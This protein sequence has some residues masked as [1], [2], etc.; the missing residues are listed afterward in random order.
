M[1]FYDRYRKGETHSVYA[2]I[3]KLGEEAFSPVFYTDVEKV[4]METFRRVKLNLDIIYKE[5]RNI[6]YVFWKDEEGNIQALLRPLSDVDEQLDILERNIESIGKLPMSVKMFYKTVG[7]CDFSWNYQDDPNILWELADPIQI[8]SLSDC[9]LQ[10][11]D[12]YWFEEMEEYIQNK[13]FGFAFLELSADNFHKDNMSGGAAYALQLNYERSIDGK[14]LNEP[15]NT[16]FI[17]YLR[18][19]FESCGFPSISY[20]DNKIYQEFCDKVKPQLLKI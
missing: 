4:L 11:T 19:C 13:G 3:E 16:T 18:I 17:N 20:E 6:N 1:N 5:L 15:N 8:I 2:D 9:I 12:Q 14:F 10:V 7:S